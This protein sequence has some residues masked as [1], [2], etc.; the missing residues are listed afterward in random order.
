VAFEPQDTPFECAPTALHGSLIS[1]MPFGPT[2]IVKP[3]ESPGAA[4]AAIEEHFDGGL[5]HWLGGTDDWKVDIA[6]VR[7]GSLALFSPSLEI[8][9]YML[10][11][12]AR[13]DKGGVTWV[14]RAAN[15]NDYFQA[16][17]AVAPGGGFEFRRVAVLGG[18]AETPVCRPVGTLSSAPASRGAVTLRTQVMGDEFTVFLDGKLVETWTDG[19]LASGGIGF[20]GAPEDRARLY[21]VKLTPAGNHHKEYSK[22]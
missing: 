20:A 7:A 4:A 11:F 21:W 17:L 9:D 2:G 18:S 16:T 12:L 19:R 22:S 6:G 13:I 5:H 1:G 8:L 14:F 3:M 15:F 10:E